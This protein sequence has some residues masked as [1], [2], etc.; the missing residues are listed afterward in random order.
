MQGVV[1]FFIDDRG[2]GFIQRDDGGDDVFLHRTQLMKIG[3]DSTEAGAR[4][5]FDLGRPKG[6][7]EAVNLKRMS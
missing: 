3:L 2:M 5:S 7:T 1:K 6:R 4:F